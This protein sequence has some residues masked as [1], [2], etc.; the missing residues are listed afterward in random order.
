MNGIDIC[1]RCH[2][3]SYYQDLRETWHKDPKSP[4]GLILEL[5]CRDETACKDR[6]DRGTA[7]AVRDE[8]TTFSAGILRFTKKGTM[9]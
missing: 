8:R 4:T 1:N 5:A 2:Y 7:P 3:S 9:G 6:T